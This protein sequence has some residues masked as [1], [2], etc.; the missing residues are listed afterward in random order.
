MSSEITPIVINRFPNEEKKVEVKAEAKELMPEEK[1]QPE[2]SSKELTPQEIDSA[3]AMGSMLSAFLSKT[4]QN[5]D[6][7]NVK[8]IPTGIGVLDTILGG[9]V[10]TKLF[11]VVGQ[12][13][14]GK[15]ALVARI[16][17]TAQ[18]TWPAKFM[19]VYIDSESAMSEDRLAELGVNYPR[20]KPYCE[21]ISVEK[22]FKFVEQICVLKTEH[23]EYM[24]I[25]ACVVW[26][27]IANTLSDKGMEVED[28]NSV[29]G[30]KAAVLSHLLPKYV[31]KMSK[32]NVSLIGVNQLRDKIE[33][34][35]TH[36]P[37]T[38]KFLADK[39]IPGGNSLLYNSSQLIF[40]RQREVLKD[41]GFDGIIVSVRSIK[42][43]LF[44]PNIEVE[45]VFSYEHGYSNFWSNYELLKK[46]K[47]V[48]VGGGWVTL[49]GFSGKK[50][51]QKQ[52]I[53]KYKEDSEFK[54][55][56][57]NA[58]KDLLKTEY[59]DKYQTGNRRQIEVW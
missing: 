44:T 45:L 12:P 23:P 6:D 36:A 54:E 46:F 59:L 3:N 2:S 31:N 7:S 14:C 33:M 43:K 49:D 16:L 37:P 32:Y 28:K 48:T 19:S 15:S 40:L 58:V 5:P 1:S 4:I 25:P 30:Q 22:V 20:I 41:Y 11:Q 50:C 24:D 17:A 52:A 34:G 26:D 53:Q 38:L 47:R 13:G 39:N 51:Q 8:V 18:R 29:M 55:A 42:N 21:D 9:G 56:W 27:S 35:I 10:A 57:D